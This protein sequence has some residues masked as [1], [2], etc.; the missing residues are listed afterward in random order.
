MKRS[1]RLLEVIGEYNLPFSVYL[2]VEP[3]GAS[4]AQTL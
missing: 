4:L 1:G 3:I 2:Y